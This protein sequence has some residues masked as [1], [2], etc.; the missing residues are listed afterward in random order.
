MTEMLEDMMHSLKKKIF[1]IILIEIVCP[2]L[3]RAVPFSPMASDPSQFGYAPQ[4]SITNFQMGQV[5]N[6]CNPLNNMAA[7]S[8]TIS[9]KMNNNLLG[10]G[11]Q[12]TRKNPI[13]HSFQEIGSVCPQLASPS[14]DMQCIGSSRTPI[15]VSSFGCEMRQDQ[16]QQIK[17]LLQAA[18]CSA[19]CQSTKLTMETN[20]I[21]CV[22]SQLDNITTS[23][24]ALQ[25]E[26]SNAILNQNKIVHEYDANIKDQALKDEFVLEKLNGK[27]G[28]KGLIQ[29]QAI[30]KEALVG[31]ATRTG[32]NTQIA[33]FGT[34]YA[35]LQQ[36]QGALQVLIRVHSVSKCVDEVLHDPMPN[37]HCTRT[38]PA[39]SLKEYILCRNQQGAM[40][41]SSGR[42]NNS[43][44]MYA[45]SQAKNQDLQ[46][47]FSQLETSISSNADTQIP[48]PTGD[49]KQDAAILSKHA[50]MNVLIQSEQDLSN[51]FKSRFQSFT[52]NGKNLWNDILAPSF[53]PN[54][55]GLCRHA[56]QEVAREE[57]T[58]GSAIYQNELQIKSQKEMLQSNLQSTIQEDKHLL[59]DA[60]SVLGIVSSIDASAC[61][62]GDMQIEINCIKNIKDTVSNVLNGT[63]GQVISFPIMGSSSNDTVNCSSINQ[64]VT[65]LQN[66][67]KQYKNNIN[68]QTKKKD[69]FVKGANQAT[70]QKINEIVNTFQAQGS[71][72]Q[73]AV[74]RI[75]AQ[76][77][78]MGVSSSFGLSVIRKEDLVKDPET[79]LYKTPTNVAAV[80]GAKMSPPLLDPQDFL[81][82]NNDIVAKQNTVNQDLSQNQM[83]LARIDGIEDSCRARD[84]DLMVQN[85]VNQ[86]SQA[87]Y[88]HGS[89]YCQ[90]GQAGSARAIADITSGL[91]FIR[92]TQRGSLSALSTALSDICTPPL[93]PPSVS[94]VQA[95]D[96]SDDDFKTRKTNHLNH[97]SMQTAAIQANVYQSQMACNGAGASIANLKGMV[98]EAKTLHRPSQA[99]SAMMGLSSPYL[100]SY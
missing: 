53:D 6:D 99:G 95:L 94:L 66:T 61:N 58:P 29:E 38:G 44:S 63:S 64:C 89:H 96:E 78:K 56:Y 12:G 10:S 81:N 77:G 30:L 13:G 35:Q 11:F 57:V 33:S 28:Q 1:W 8:A 24:Q 86:L 62:T 51:Q 43:N 68:T 91:Q 41:D 42:I 70:E 15:D 65:V 37:Y 79:G 4:G 69:A 7:I 76:L 100:N 22:K 31:S 26:F 80:A 39:V 97:E 20:E 93:T 59:Q 27:N 87:R 52:I 84:N 25:N 36:A 32:L 98:D 21:L 14:L 75:K 19:L 90:G 16:M 49:P 5:T 9:Q 17:Y 34:Q 50:S 88:C 60:Y 85:M 54:R 3:S 55:S 71:F 82:A 47:V 18:E 67:E 45:Q 2:A 92:V 83:N 23:I 40:L 74:R 72:L 48:V 73:S 46:T